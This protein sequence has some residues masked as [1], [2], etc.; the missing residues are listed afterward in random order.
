[1]TSR[2]AQQLLTIGRQR[3]AAA[4]SAASN[5]GIRGRSAFST[6][7]SKSYAQPVGPLNAFVQTWYNLY[8]KQLCDVT[9]AINNLII[10]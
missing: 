8:V 9:V 4:T 2:L 10:E 1:M 5:S 7:I 3:V 6:Q